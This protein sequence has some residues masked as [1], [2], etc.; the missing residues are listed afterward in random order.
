[1]CWSKSDY[2]FTEDFI[3][4]CKMIRIDDI[5]SFSIKKENNSHFNILCFTKHG[6]MFICK[7]CNCIED[8]LMYLEK[9][10]NE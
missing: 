8:A 4:D 10:P 5:S 9:M 6:E 2:E 7:K 1:M 3:M